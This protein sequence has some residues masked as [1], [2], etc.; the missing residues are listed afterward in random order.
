MPI[1]RLPESVHT[2]YAEI[3]DQTL[4]ADAEAGA[5]RLPATPYSPPATA[6]GAPLRT[7]ANSAAATGR[8]KKKP[9]TWW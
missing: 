9:W 1:D 5:E 3:F 6:T 7:S 4:Q 2:L 8:L